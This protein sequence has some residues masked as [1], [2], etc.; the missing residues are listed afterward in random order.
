MNKENLFQIAVKNDEIFK[1][2]IGYKEYE[3]RFEIA[4]M[5]TNVSTASYLISLYLKD[6]PNFNIDKI[7][8]AFA[9]LSKSKEWSWLI[10]YYVSCFLSE[11][12]DFLPLDIL[13]ENLQ[14]NKE[15]LLKNTGW[16]CFN[17]RPTFNNIWDIIVRENNKQRQKF[18]I[19]ILY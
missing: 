13:Y 5:P 11:K 14:N 16:I 2:L 7:I 1:F 8:N 17:F 10:V 3:I 6:T 9:E 18:D 12:M 19:P 15:Y 4:Y